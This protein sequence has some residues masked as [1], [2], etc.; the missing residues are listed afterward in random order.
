MRESGHR[1]G[2]V[3]RSELWSR[4]S[5][6]GV[7]GREIEYGDGDGLRRGGKHDNAAVVGGNVAV[8]CVGLRHGDNPQHGFVPA[9][10]GI[11]DA[12][13]GSVVRA[14]LHHPG[15]RI[16]QLRNAVGRDGDGDSVAWFAADIFLVPAFIY[17]YRRIRRDCTMPQTE[18]AKSF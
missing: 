7:D 5:A 13:A 8:V 11:H 2:H 18:T 6:T 10:V 14:P 4:A 12:S 3:H 15:R 17:V 1:H 9:C 16:H